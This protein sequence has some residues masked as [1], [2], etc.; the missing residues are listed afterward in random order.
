MEIVGQVK[1]IKLFLFFTF[2]FIGI[3]LVIF[4]S[5][6]SSNQGQFLFFSDEAYVNLAVAKHLA[7]NRVYGLTPYGFSP[8]SSSP[9]WVVLNALFYRLLKTIS[10]TSLLLNVLLGLLLLY[11]VHKRTQGWENLW[12]KVLF[13][14]VV[15]TVFPLFYL[16]FSGSEQLFFALI[17]FVLMLLLEEYLKGEQENSFF[18]IFVLLSLAVVTRYEAFAIVL[19][20]SLFFLLKKELKKSVLILASLI[21]PVI[22]GVIN[23]SK[24]WGFF[25]VPVVLKDFSPLVRFIRALTATSPFHEFYQA[26]LYRFHEILSTWPESLLLLSFIT[27]SFLISGEERLRI[28]MRILSAMAFFHLL[29][30]RISLLSVTYLVAI[31]FFVFILLV[32]RKTKLFQTIQIKRF[33]SG[34]M[35]LILVLLLGLRSVKNLH[36]VSLSRNL[37]LSNYQLAKFLSIF[38]LGKT[39][40]SNVS[41]TVNFFTDLRCVDLNGYCNK[42]IYK[43]L[44]KRKFGL[45]K[46]FLQNLSERIGG[47]IA[48]LAGDI[49]DVLIP[50]KWFE[51][52]RWLVAEE[53]G[54]RY[55]IMFFSLARV[56]L[57]QD[58]RLFSAMLPGG[59][60]EEGSYLDEKEPI[61]HGKFTL[62]EA[63]KVK[64]MTYQ[65]LEKGEIFKVEEDMPEGPYRIYIK[66]KSAGEKTLLRVEVLHDRPFAKNL[67]IDP[68]FFRSYVVEVKIRKSILFRQKGKVRFELKNLSNSPVLLD[69]VLFEKILLRE[70]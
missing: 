70:R 8:S 57:D 22:I 66:A 9:A 19:M 20:L 25:P 38:Y 60:L 32:E 67:L 40:L 53:K 56:H 34:I 52:G 55:R 46:Y 64:G 62:F 50:E 68:G 65:V 17:I 16:V 59:I 24:G 18:W 39:V 10:E 58:L 11:F 7:E 35:I 3:S 41:G 5:I 54:K 23:L 15:I 49:P 48:V 33:L 69:K 14:A 4:L 47:D 45:D 51:V 44:L 36:I 30:V 61:F 2:L 29:F 37:Y 26:T 12:L 13:L 42:L 28:P 21:L 1:K 43:E 6:K 27:L 31:A 63:E